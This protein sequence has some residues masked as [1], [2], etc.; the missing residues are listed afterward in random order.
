MTV[1]ALTATTS[2]DAVRRRRGGGGRSAGSH[3]RARHGGAAR[4]NGRQQV[5]RLLQ[6]R[7]ADPLLPHLVLLAMLPEQLLALVPPRAHCARARARGRARG[8]AVTSCG[9]PPSSRGRDL[10]GRTG[11]EGGEGPAA[12]GHQSLALGRSQRQIH[13]DAHEVRDGV[14]VAGEREQLQG[15]AGQGSEEYGNEG[16]RDVG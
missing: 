12:V 3:A 1:G 8:R 15:R 4:G 9:T 16:Q 7:V 2:Q 5:V 13:H 10:R 6:L 11:G 14:A